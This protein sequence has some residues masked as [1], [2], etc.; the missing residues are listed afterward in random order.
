MSEVK[1]RKSVVPWVVGGVLLGL[2]QVLAIGLVRPLGFSEPFV[3]TDGVVVRAVAEEYA[4]A[5]PLLSREDYQKPGYG[6]WVNVGIIIGG[7]IAALATRRWTLRKTCAWS[8]VN[9][10]PSVGKRLVV[11]FVAGFLALLGA[12][13]AHGCSTG[14]FLSGWAQ[15]SVSVLP[16]T[17][18]PFAGGMLAARIAYPRI[19]E[20]ER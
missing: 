1:V 9:H 15:L 5:H 11:C 19:P 7:A 2:L 20:I 4:E 10:G 3:I 17:A 14:Q 18:A 12:R 13:L 16:F 6:R 8:L